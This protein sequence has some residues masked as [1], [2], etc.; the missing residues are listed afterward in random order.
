MRQLGRVTREPTSIFFTGGATAVLV[1]WRGTTVDVDLRVE[2]QRDE[3]FR[4][5]A[6]LKERLDVNLELASPEEFV[7][8]H[9]DWRS[10]SV[11]IEKQGALSF[12]HFDLHAQALAKVERGHAQDVA[13]VAAMLARGL[14]GRESRW[15]YYQAVA[16][17]VYRYPALDSSALERALEL[18]FGPGPTAA[19]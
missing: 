2:P 4:A 3:V 11:F 15:A 8:V 7:P 1:G 17:R 14:V 13:D 10:R 12:F 9:P 18:T 6:E 16:P 19:D 5:L